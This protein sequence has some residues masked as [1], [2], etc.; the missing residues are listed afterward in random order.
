VPVKVTLYP[1]RAKIFPSASQGDTVSTESENFSKVSGEVSVRYP[2]VKKTREK[3]EEKIFPS[4]REAFL[5]QSVSSPIAKYGARGK[6]RAPSRTFAMSWGQLV[7]A[8]RPYEVEVKQVCLFEVGPAKSGLVWLGSGGVWE[9][10]VSL[11]SPCLV[12]CLSVQSAGLAEPNVS[13]IALSPLTTSRTPHRSSVG[14]DLAP[15][16]VFFIDRVRY[17]TKKLG[18]ESAAAS[19]QRRQVY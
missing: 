11:P 3:E 4:D 10:S 18:A 17:A 15:R 1:Q 16:G 8:K 13:R 5:R 19:P 7:W 12:P 14:V 6:W 9:V 2:W